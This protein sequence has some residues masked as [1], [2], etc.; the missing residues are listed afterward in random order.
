MTQAR[1]SLKDLIPEES[2][3]KIISGLQ[4]RI[5][6]LK[7]ENASEVKIAEAYLHLA[8]TKESFL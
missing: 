6:Q 7:A 4:A 5:E 2:R 8:K 1:P 3:N